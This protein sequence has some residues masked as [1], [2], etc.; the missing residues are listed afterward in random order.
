VGKDEA[1]PEV[2]DANDSRSGSRDNRSPGA[3]TKLNGVMQ[4]TTRKHMQRIVLRELHQ[5][6]S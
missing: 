5:S 4:I 6:A 1:R 2:L 3:A